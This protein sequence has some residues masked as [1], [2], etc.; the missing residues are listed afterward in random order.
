MRYVSTGLVLATLFSPGLTARATDTGPVLVPLHVTGSS[1]VAGPYHLD[2]GEADEPEAARGWQ[3]PIRI[4]GPGKARCTVSDDVSIVEK[5][6]SRVGT[7]LVYVT[8]YSG[9]E[10]T[11]FAIDAATCQTQWKSPPFTGRPVMTGHTL[12]LPGLHGFSIGKSGLPVR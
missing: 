6:I 9:S 10:S 4:A 3:G 5:P 12:S 2:L 11:L 8:T 1:V 7:R